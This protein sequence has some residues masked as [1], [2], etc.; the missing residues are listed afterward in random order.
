MVRAQLGATVLNSASVIVKLFMPLLFRDSYAL[1]FTN[2]GTLMATYGAG[3]IA[4][5]YAGGSLTGRV[6]ARKLT[7][8]SL[9]ASGVLAIY[10]ACSL[11]VAWLFIVVPAIGVADG[12]FRP[13]NLR[14][15]MEA[16]SAGDATWLQG[17]HRICFNLGVAFAGAV[18]AALSNIGYPALFATAGVANVMGGCL[19]LR[20]MRDARG[21]G[22][23]RTTCCSTRRSPVCRVSVSPWTDRPFLLFVL[24][25]LLA[26]GVF[27][28]MYGAFGLF[29]S[30]DYGL[31]ASWLG[32]L[33]CLNA[34]LI[35][36]V[37]APAMALIRRIGIL[38]ASRWGTLLLAIA[39]PLLNLGRSPA[40]AIATIMCI[41]AS[42]ILLT[43]AWTLAVM[44]RS[45]GRDRGRYLGIFTA[46]WLG[47]S[48]YGPAAGTWIYGMFGGAQL[49]W[50]C[51]AV[52][53]VVWILHLR[54]L[55]KLGNPPSSDDLGPPVQQ[56]K[57]ED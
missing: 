6:D 38:A 24:G 43:P 25:Q 3:C 2:I 51:A 46:A 44:D 33:F 34:I 56:L 22:Q 1:D 49:W 52:G 36:F 17:A 54:S 8:V 20:Y 12:A 48:L 13:A 57:V 21:G 18:S 31:D 39:F 11:D 28:Q 10:L 27:D 23:L 42:E 14:L 40:Y 53:A 7:A 26:L 37:Q 47:H 50:T 15:V 9:C 55:D 32:F 4:G 35:V 16:A 29:L 45:A 30:E 19:L 5:A 41:T